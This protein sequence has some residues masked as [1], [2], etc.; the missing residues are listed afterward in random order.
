[1]KTYFIIIIVSF[2]TIYSCSVTKNSAS[3]VLINQLSKDSR[4]N[5][6]LLGK[7]TRSAL[8]QQPFADWYKANYDS[9]AL[10]SFTCNYIRPLLAGKS[11]TI[12]MGTWCGDSRREVPRVLKMLD[13]CNFPSSSLTMIMVSNKDSLYKK[14]PQHEEAGKNIARVP[15]IIIEQKGVEIGRIIEFP[16]TSL[17]NDLLAILRKEKYQP[18]YHQL[19]TTSR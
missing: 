3:P 14:S 8:L 5:D 12:F 15:T 6:M 16:I 2:V 9:Y 4:G 19:K 10:D 13:C 1:M 18:N 11:I 17:E 7:C